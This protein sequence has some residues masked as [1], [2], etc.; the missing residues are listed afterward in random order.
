MPSSSI[1]SSNLSIPM[2]GLN[3]GAGEEDGFSLVHV[4]V[5]QKSNSTMKR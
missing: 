1:K 2:R 3:L 4:E 5:V